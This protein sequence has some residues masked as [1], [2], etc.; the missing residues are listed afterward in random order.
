MS[1]KKIDPETD[2]VI[3]HCQKQPKYCKPISRP[4]WSAMAFTKVVSIVPVQRLRRPYMEKRLRCLCCRSVRFAS[5]AL[6]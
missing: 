1:D 4:V 2:D 3:G 6:V 5:L